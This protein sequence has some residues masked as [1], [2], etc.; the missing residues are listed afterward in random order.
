MSAKGSQ[1]RN[2]VSPGTIAARG[3]PLCDRHIH[4]FTEDVARDAAQRSA[5]RTKYDPGPLPLAGDEE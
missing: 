4:I 2:H 1:C 5:M 3:L